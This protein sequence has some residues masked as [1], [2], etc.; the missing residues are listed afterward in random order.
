MKNKSNWNYYGVRIVK[1]IMLADPHDSNTFVE[2]FDYDGIQTFEESI[3]LVHAKSE[4]HAYRVARER[5]EKDEISYLNKFNELVI[6]RLVDIVDCYEI[7][8]KL[9][10]GAEI[11]SC[12]HSTKDNVEE[13]M[14]KWFRVIDE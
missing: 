14:D 3:M 9:E 4:D 13:F 8:D 11:Y 6:W 10:S 7:V 5:I 2:L 1:Q 12:F